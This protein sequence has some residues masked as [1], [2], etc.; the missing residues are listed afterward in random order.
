MSYS[1]FEICK[2]CYSNGESEAQYRSHLLKN[3][4][5]LVTCPVLM[6]Y[7]CPICNAKGALAHTLRLELI[8]LFL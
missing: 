2:F 5:G 4:Y 8:K 6:S 1:S 3:S 7:T